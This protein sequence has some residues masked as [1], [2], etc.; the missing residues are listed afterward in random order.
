MFPDR[1]DHNDKNYKET[2]RERLTSFRNDDG[3]LDMD[4]IMEVTHQVNYSPL[5]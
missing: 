5:S 2:V 4:K 1:Y 3:S